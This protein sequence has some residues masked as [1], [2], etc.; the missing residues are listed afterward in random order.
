MKDVLVD[1]YLSLIPWRLLHAKGKD[2]TK[3]KYYGGLLFYDHVSTAMFI[4]NQV[5][6][7]AGG[8]N[9][10]THIRAMRKGK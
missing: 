1:Q 8:K 6:L 9:G 5:S 4:V 3:N 10:K 2:P 7:R